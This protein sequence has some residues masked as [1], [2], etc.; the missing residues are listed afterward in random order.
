MQAPRKQY[1]ICD[2]YD[3]SPLN[4]NQKP[5]EYCSKQHPDNYPCAI[6]ATYKIH[7]REHYQISCNRYDNGRNRR[8]RELV[9]HIQ[10]NSYD[11]K[12]QKLC[13]DSPQTGSNK[14]RNNHA[15]KL[16]KKCTSQN[17]IYKLMSDSQFVS[18]KISEDLLKVVHILF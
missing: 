1:K 3:D 8:I 16:H 14:S 10:N 11:Q 5:C 12:H 9:C 6:S 18:E 15:R 4:I 7:N 17:H 2:R 13:Q